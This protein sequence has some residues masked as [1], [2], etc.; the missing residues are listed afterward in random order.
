MA[1]H[2][3]IKPINDYFRLPK[4]KRGGNNLVH[5]ITYSHK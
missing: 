5:E 2:F 1:F 3:T 4:E